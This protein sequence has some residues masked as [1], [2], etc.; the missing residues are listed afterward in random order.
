MPFRSLHTQP[1]AA[2]S[3]LGSPGAPALQERLLPVWPGVPC[4][5][6]ARRRAAPLLPAFPPFATPCC[7]LPADFYLTWNDPSAFETVTRTTAEWLAGNRSC[8]RECTDW[9][10]D[11]ACCD[12]IY[13]PTFFLRNVYALPQDRATGYKMVVLAPPQTSVAW[14]SFVQARVPRCCAAPVGWVGF[15]L[16]WVGGGGRPWGKVGGCPRGVAGEALFRS[17][18][19]C[20]PAS[21]SLL[22]PQPPPPHPS[23]HQPQ[24]A[25]TAPP[26]PPRAG[27]LL[28]AHGP[29]PLPL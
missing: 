11:V 14:Y 8:E 23:T 16:V 12:A 5:S 15:V 22:R 27:H 4:A 29:H 7:S 18:P 3:S 19:W 13:L 2:Q 21:P 9:A 6:S 20:N 1:A 26:P 17:L 24:R 10:G 28:P 25:A